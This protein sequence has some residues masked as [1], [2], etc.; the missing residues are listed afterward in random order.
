MGD[1]SG[2]TVR[3]RETLKLRKGS[4]Y[5]VTMKSTLNENAT[6]FHKHHE[7]REVQFLNEISHIKGIKNV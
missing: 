7:V 4:V 6:H 3:H 5:M 2:S 1:I